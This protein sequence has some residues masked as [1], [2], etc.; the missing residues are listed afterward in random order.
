MLIA[1][2]SLFRMETHFCKLGTHP[3]TTS[4]LPESS[5]KAKLWIAQQDTPPKTRHTHFIKETFRLKTK[6][7]I[8]RCDRC[9]EH[10]SGVLSEGRS[11]LSR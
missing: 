4:G 9:D 2:R 7:V 10:L 11:A 8:V 6:S 1:L 5:H 3:R